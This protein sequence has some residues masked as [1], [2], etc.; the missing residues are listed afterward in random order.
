MEPAVTAD[1]RVTWELRP[2]LAQVNLRLDP[3]L[4]G[5]V[6]HPL[7][8]EPNTTWESG[9][10]AAL[11]LG[12]DEWL[13]MG[14][15]DDGPRIVQELDAA[16]R[17]THHSVV[18]VSA[19]RVALELRGPGANELLSKG[20]SLD[21]HPR[22]WTT[23]SCA[24]TMLAK[25]PVILHERDDVTRILVRTSFTDYLIDWFMAPAVP[26]ADRSDTPVDPNL[27]QS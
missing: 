13:L 1:A 17:G 3:S 19:N 18:D 26:G 15:A 11:W 7:P 12:P 5:S 21:L 14:P 10:S 24:Q 25:A 8:L 9:S 20:C 22:F 2:H 4:A 27:G 6:S 16:L 23:G